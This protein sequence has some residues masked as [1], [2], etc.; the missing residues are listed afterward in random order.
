MRSLLTIVAA[1]CVPSLAY[2]QAATWRDSA[3][4]ACQTDLCR[5]SV[6]AYYD[7]SVSRGVRFM[8]CVE[9]FSL[10]NA[11]SSNEAAQRVASSGVDAC[12][13]E[14]NEYRE[15]TR[16]MI[17]NDPRGKN[18]AQKSLEDQLTK[19]LVENAT[20]QVIPRILGLRAERKQ[21]PYESQ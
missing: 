13:R 21:T 8:T 16:L 6:E 2:G 14:L 7:Q 5:N 11:L 18:P 19:S 10:A 15:A 12:G 1:V 17:T 9:T 3:L 20:S 4:K